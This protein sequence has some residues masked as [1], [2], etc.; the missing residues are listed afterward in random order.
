MTHPTHQSPSP[1][2]V[3]PLRIVF[4]ETTS[5]C[6]LGCAHCRRM[7]TGRDQARWNL[8]TA[9]GGALVDDLSA[10]HPQALLI[11][12]GG[13]PLLRPDIFTLA[14]R[15]R[16][17]GL[18]TALA[19]NGT[20][21]TP[22]VARHI[23]GAG[24]ARVS[25]SLDGALASTHDLLRGVAGSFDRALAGL[26]LVRDAGQ[27]VQINMSVTRANAAELAA[28]FRLAEAE[29]A[30]ALHLFIV[31]PVGCGAEL[32]DDQR[33]SPEEYEQL[34][35]EFHGL[36]AKSSVETRATCAPQ[37]ARIT[38]Q[39]AAEHG[40]GPETASRGPAGAPGHPAE[41]PGGCL[42]GTGAVFVSHRGDVFPCGYLPIRC[43]NVREETLS[44][45]WQTSVVLGRL[46]RRELLTGKCGACDWREACGGC[47]ARAF[48]ATG[49]P[50]AAEPDCIYQPPQ[51]THP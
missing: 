51:P 49:D 29:R 10:T 37:Y 50:M 47:R 48:A 28:M 18:R 38:A 33:L 3:P 22:E 24:F 2:D 39:L 14:E 41:R 8:S 20:L 43:G 19:T 31:V 13:E 30:A 42:A 4:W 26:R 15:A 16:A 35:R 12:S 45:L 17:A 36:S 5:A 27:S 46:R 1:D 9:E 32:R 11:L 44:T 40:R 23:A 25:V 6:N 34:L 7:D 21:V